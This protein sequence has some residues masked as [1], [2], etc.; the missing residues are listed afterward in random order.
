MN[1]WVPTTARILSNIWANVGFSWTLL[2]GASKSQFLENK[3]LTHTCLQVRPSVSPSIIFV[4][5][6]G[7]QPHMCYWSLYIP[8]ERAGWRQSV[9]YPNMKLFRCD[10][11]SGLSLCVCALPASLSWQTKT[12]FSP[13]QYMYCTSA[14]SLILQTSLA[15]FTLQSSSAKLSHTTHRLHQVIFLAVRYSKDRTENNLTW[16]IIPQLNN[17]G[18]SRIQPDLVPDD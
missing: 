13:P 6:D 17:L 4:T 9:L 15:Y 1:F 16:S 3:Q 14:E 5:T 18:T 2:H 11:Y 12:R 8:D 10:V 7:Y